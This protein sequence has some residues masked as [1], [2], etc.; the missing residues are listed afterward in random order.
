MIGSDSSMIFCWIGSII[1]LE[2]RLSD[3]VL[4]E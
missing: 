2:E 4:I 1:M 3:I